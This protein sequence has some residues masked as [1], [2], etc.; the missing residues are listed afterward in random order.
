MEKV[1]QDQF[2]TVSKQY[3]S[4]ETGNEASSCQ[5][6]NKTGSQ[7]LKGDSVLWKISPGM[8][9]CLTFKWMGDTG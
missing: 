3:N 9:Q 5:V 8:W 2:F 6:Q 4:K 1:N 7:H